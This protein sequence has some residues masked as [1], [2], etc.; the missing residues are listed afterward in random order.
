MCT[1]NYNSFI[2]ISNQKLDV[3]A[4]VNVFNSYKGIKGIIFLQKG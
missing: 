2:Q 3:S 4:M 1:L